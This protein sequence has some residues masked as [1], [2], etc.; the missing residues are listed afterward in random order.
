MKPRPSPSF[1]CGWARRCTARPRWSDRRCSRL[2][3]YWRGANMQDRRINRLKERLLA[4][5]DEVPVIRHLVEDNPRGDDMLGEVC[6]AAVLLHPSASFEQS[7]TLARTMAYIVFIDDYLEEDHPELDLGD[8]RRVCQNFLLWHNR[9][10]S[11]MPLVH[12]TVARKIEDQFREDEVPEEWTAMRRLVWEKSIWT[13]LQE[14][15][16]LKHHERVTLDAYLANGM[17]SSSFPIVQV[18]ILAFS[19]QDVSQELKNRIF[20]HICQAA[21]VVRLANDLRTHEREAAQGRFNSVDLIFSGP[22]DRTLESAREAVH[23]LME[24]E[25]EQL[26]KAIARERRTGITQS[27]LSH[28]IDS[29]QV[30]LDFYEV[31]RQGRPDRLLK[32]G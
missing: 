19:Y 24:E 13:M 9:D 4:Q 20:G 29:T 21:R 14:N 5:A 27:F 31:P 12:A 6:R 28:L 18:S 8:Y 11:Q 26:K 25:F 1:L 30:L 16:W 2:R 7:L 10:L 17:Y 22:S 32:A 23:H 15:H 3:S